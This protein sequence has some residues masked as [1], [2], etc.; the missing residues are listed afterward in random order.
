MPNTKVAFSSL[1]T[2]KNKKDL[3]KK[4]VEVKN[5]L[6]YFCAQTNIDFIDNTNIKEDHLGNKK[7]HLNKGGNTVLANNLL[8][9]LRSA[10]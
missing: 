9:H 5:R 4:V 7:L 1:I 8:K 3:D 10:F 6:K 2:R